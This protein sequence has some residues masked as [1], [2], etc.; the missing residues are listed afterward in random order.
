MKE[1][2]KGVRI[3]VFFN[4]AEMQAGKSYYVPENLAEIKSHVVTEQKRNLVDY[5]ENLKATSPVILLKYNKG[6]TKPSPHQG[7]KLKDLYG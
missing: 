7:K 4:L 1:I 3:D 5:I 2:M 6:K